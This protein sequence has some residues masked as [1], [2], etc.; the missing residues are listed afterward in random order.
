MLWNL[1]ATIRTGKPVTDSREVYVEPKKHD[2]MPWKEVFL[3]DP[4]LYTVLGIFFCCLWFFLPSYA[5]VGALAGGIALTIKGIARFKATH[6]SWSFWY[7][8]LLEN[9]LPFTVLTF[10]AVAIGGLLQ[11][12]PTVIVNRGDRI[13]GRIQKLYTPLELCGRDI[14]VSEGCYN[15]HSQMIRQMVPD[16]LRYGTGR[17][18]DYS[19]LGE[20]IYDHPF[21]WGSKRTGPD[22]AR[23][24]SKRDYTW[25]VIH[26]R[27]PRDMDRNST[28]PNY[29]WLFDKKAD[30]DALPGKIAAQ[31]T[32][33]VPYEPMTA[34]VI[35]DKARAQAIEISAVLKGQGQLVEPDRQI[36]ALV[37]YLKA[38]GSWEEKL[39]ATDKSGDRPSLTPGNPD[40]H[41][42]VAAIPAPAN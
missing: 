19:H 38:L 14:Y 21:Q 15:C 9:F 37:A 26:L 10:I 32:L 13:E 35:K 33:G 3:N 30:I 24:G 36:I 17:K 12:I 40:N 29:P 2:S 25:Q 8:K 6:Q 42:P 20:S 7:E 39:P 27:N 34:D 16:V 5:N 28:M 23:E 4:I 18:D 1:F 31:R 41:R 11:I 22:L